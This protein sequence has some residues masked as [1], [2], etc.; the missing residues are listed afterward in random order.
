[1]NKP[2]KLNKADKVAIVSL[3]SGIHGM[4]Y[5]KHE[6]KIKLKRLKE[7]ELVHVI[8]P[9]ALK[10]VDYIKDHPEERAAWI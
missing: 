2:Q 10:G 7:M 8:M 1:M 4:P 9:N 3:S 5:C 6:L